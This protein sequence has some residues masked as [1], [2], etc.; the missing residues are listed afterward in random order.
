MGVPVRK[1]RIFMCMLPKDQRSYPLTVTVLANAKVKECIGFVCYKY[2][3]E[4][5]DQHIQSVN[6]LYIYIYISKV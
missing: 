6:L 1:Y 2:M 5:P 4:H 3:K